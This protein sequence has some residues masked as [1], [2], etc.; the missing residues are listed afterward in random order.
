MYNLKF[1]QLQTMILTT[2]GKIVGLL[3]RRSV[4]RANISGSMRIKE[5]SDSQKKQR[6]LTSKYW[7]LSL[8][9]FFPNKM[10]KEK[11][12]LSHPSS[13]LQ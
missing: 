8:L 11:A 13:I 10:G 7:Q 9:L 3:E 4:A 5:V 1:I 6:M 12:E 2:C